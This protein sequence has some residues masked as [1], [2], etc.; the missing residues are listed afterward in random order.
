M[1]TLQW[2]DVSVCHGLTECRFFHRAGGSTSGRSHCITACSPHLLAIK[3]PILKTSVQLTS[4]SVGRH[5]SCDVVHSD[6]LCSPCV[7]LP[8]VIHLIPMLRLWQYSPSFGR[9]FSLQLFLHSSCS[10]LLPAT[11]TGYHMWYTT[12]VYHHRYPSPPHSDHLPLSCQSS[13]YNK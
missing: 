12:C 6:I 10:L 1:M 2:L 7:S 13:T 11:V 5:S 9:Q 4:V 8:V 3:L